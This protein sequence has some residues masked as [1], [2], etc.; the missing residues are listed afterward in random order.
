MIKN[1]Y[2]PSD[3]LQGK[4]SEM[5]HFTVLHSSS[6]SPYCPDGW[7]T[8]SGRCFKYF[9]NTFDWIS[10]EDHCLSLDANLV[11]IHNENEYQMVKALIRDKD[12]KDKYAVWIGLSACQKVKLRSIIKI[13]IRNS[14]RGFQFLGFL[15]LRTLMNLSC[16]TERTLALPFLGCS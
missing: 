10:A 2:F 7:V 5:E 13:F 14:G 4:I 8:Y 11:S 3:S 16:T 1:I 12:P 15:R 9:N 6:C